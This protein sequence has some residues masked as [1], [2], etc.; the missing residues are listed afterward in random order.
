MERNEQP[1]HVPWE[2]VPGFF[3]YVVGVAAGSS[4]QLLHL[5]GLSMF[6]SEPKPITL[7]QAEVLEEGLCSHKGTQPRAWGLAYRPCQVQATVLSMGPAPQG[8]FPSAPPLGRG[9]LCPG[10][11]TIGQLTRNRIPKF[12][13]VPNHRANASGV[14]APASKGKCGAKGQLG[15]CDPCRGHRAGSG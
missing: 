2:R 12:L 6:S 10:L 14:S 15:S 4:P 13:W 5:A 1:G 8:S 9:S 7:P 3:S 11:N